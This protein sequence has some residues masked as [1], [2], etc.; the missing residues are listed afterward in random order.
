MAHLREMVLVALAGALNVKLLTQV[1]DAGVSPGLFFQAHSAFD[2][3]GIEAVQRRRNGRA[4]ADQPRA[5]PRSV[6][7]PKVP[8]GYQCPPLR[9]ITKIIAVTSSLWLD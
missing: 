3:L 9:P 6:S 7:G 5:V 2:G 1:H 8:L 4:L